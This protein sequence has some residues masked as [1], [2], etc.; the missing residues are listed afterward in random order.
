[1]KGKLVTGGRKV[2]KGNPQLTNW[3]I[4]FSRTKG[5]R[6]GR[7]WCKFVS[8]RKYILPMARWY[9]LKSRRNYF[10]DIKYFRL[11]V[12]GVSALAGA[13]VGSL[14][15]AKAGAAIGVWFGG[16]GAVVALGKKITIFGSISGAL[17]AGYF[18][19][20]AGANLAGI[21]LSS[22]YE[23]LDEEQARQVEGHIYNNYV[24]P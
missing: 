4:L 12:S 15:G 21:W 18:G 8:S 17:S 24:S 7:T 23:K 9:N 16:V 2:R 6:L 10:N 13:K 3:E 19:Y 22:Y 20:S 5:F 14:L 1:M 11:G